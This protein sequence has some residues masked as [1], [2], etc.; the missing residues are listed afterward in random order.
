MRLT[1]I[2]MLALILSTYARAQPAPQ[3]RLEPPKD[4]NCFV[5]VQMRGK[6]T[7]E[8]TVDDSN[9]T[10]TV[11]EKRTGI[12]I[13]NGNDPDIT[14]SFE[15]FLGRSV[16]MRTAAQKLNQSWVIVHGELVVL[17][18]RLRLTFYGGGYERPTV[19]GVPEPPLPRYVLKVDRLERAPEP[20]QGKDH[21]ALVT[22]EVR[23]LL[24]TNGSNP[25]LA[26]LRDN[27]AMP[28]TVVRS[29]PCDFRLF[30]GKNDD[31]LAQAKDLNGKVVVVRG[32]LRFMRYRFSSQEVFQILSALGHPTRY[33]FLSVSGLRPASVGS[34]K[35]PRDN[36]SH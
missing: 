8:K 4:V 9:E 3:P 11:Y 13:D 6:L 15:L 18:P 35:R 19:V 20:R 16:P 32:D 26:Q 2:H 1:L 29:D 30:L 17:H 22:L 5:K 12:V 34:E 28:G 23:G 27:K 10:L 31:W 7:V 36:K 21:R 33:S 25:A 14:A 24:E